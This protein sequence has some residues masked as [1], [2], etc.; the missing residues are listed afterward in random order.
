MGPVHGD[1]G[2]SQLQLLDGTYGVWGESKDWN[3]VWGTSDSGRGVR[4]D[5]MTSDGVTGSTSGT[6]HSGV[7]GFND[8]T[9]GSSEGVY[10]SGQYGVRGVGRHTGVEG[11]GLD[12]TVGTGVVGWGANAGVMAFSYTN[13]NAA[14]FGSLTSAAYIVGDVYVFGAF[15]VADK[16]LKSA[17]VQ[18]PDGSH[19]KLY[20]MES[21]ECWFEDFGI[22]QLHEGEA[23]VR[24]DH[25]FAALV[26]TDSY[27]VFVT[28]YGDS[29]G[30]FVAHMRPHSF[31]VREQQGGKHSLE[32]AYRVVAR[33]RDVTVTRLEPF[34]MPVPPVAPTRPPQT[35][36]QP[37]PPLQPPYHRP[38]A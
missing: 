6:V 2:H 17:I 28:P 20:C 19:R 12:G 25:D 37:P 16:Q 32:F 33:R 34:Q 24:L 1:Q 8:N 4:G 15:S 21:P 11:Q 9:Q 26:H 30:L 27:H 14:Y 13:N 38:T 7:A 31:V 22:G 36:R 18:H 35:P 29:N 10:G 3:G 23:D 5:S